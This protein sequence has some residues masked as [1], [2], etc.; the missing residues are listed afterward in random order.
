[1]SN[2]NL[3]SPKITELTK[4]IQSNN[5]NAVTAFWTNIEKEGSPLIEKIDGDKN[6]YTNYK[7]NI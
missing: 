4:S 5:I 6:Q 2:N 3:L 1:M 7:V